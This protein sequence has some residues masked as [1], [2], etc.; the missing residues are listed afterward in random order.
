M[1]QQKKGGNTHLKGTYK[2]FDGILRDNLIKF[3][4]HPEIF[5]T[6]LVRKRPIFW[7]KL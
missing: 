5:G 4:D 3:W 7:E 2:E 1:M 6:I